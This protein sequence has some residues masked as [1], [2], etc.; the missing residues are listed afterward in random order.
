MLKQLNLFGKDYSRITE[1]IGSRTKRQVRH[2][3]Y[4]FIERL[5]KNSNDKDFKILEILK[6]PLVIQNS[7]NEKER[8]RFTY[9]VRVFGKDFKRITE[10]IGGSKTR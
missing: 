10:H 5:E 8:D 3:T 6:Q 1:Y 9:A 4:D 7:W 2:Y